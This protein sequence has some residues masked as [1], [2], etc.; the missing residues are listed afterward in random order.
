MF[1][2]TISPL[3]G[4]IPCLNMLGTRIHG[5]ANDKNVLVGTLQLNVSQIRSLLME[6]KYVLIQNWYFLSSYAGWTNLRR[7]VINNRNG[8]SSQVGLCYPRF[9]LFKT[10]LIIFITY[11]TLTFLSSNSFSFPS[12]VSC[13]ISGGYVDVS[14]WFHTFHMH[15]SILY[16]YFPWS[17]D[18]EIML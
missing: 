3:L 15:T 7:S 10:K 14:A 4:C 9:Q 16:I 17:L 5:V 6:F 18:M 8:R 2:S 1:V 11:I 12:I 13:A